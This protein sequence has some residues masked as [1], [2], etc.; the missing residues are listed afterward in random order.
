[1][2]KRSVGSAH[3]IVMAPRSERAFSRLNVGGETIVSLG[4]AV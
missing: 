1:M 2:A 3:G 4:I